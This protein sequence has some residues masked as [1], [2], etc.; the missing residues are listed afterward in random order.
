MPDGGWEPVDP[1]PEGNAPGPDPPGGIATGGR[2]ARSPHRS[3]WLAAAAIAAVVGIVAWTVARDGGGS[4][5][6]SEADPDALSEVRER[7][8]QERTAGETLYESHRDAQRAFARASRRLQVAGSFAYQGT[9]H[10]PGPS[11]ARPAQAPAPDVAV[12]GQV[13]LPLRTH[14]VAVDAQGR[15]AE[16]VTVGPSIWQRS[17]STEDGLA[18]ATYAFAGDVTSWN[19]GVVPVGAGAARL[20]GWLEATVDRRPA[21]RTARS[22][23]EVYAGTLPADR[24]GAVQRGG[25]PVR[26][27]VELTVDRDDVPLRVVIEAFRNE[28]G[29]TSRPVWRLAVDISGLGDPVT[30][31]LPNGELP[32]VTRGPSP[33]DIRVAGIAAPVEL[34]RMPDGWMLAGI[35]LTESTRRGCPVLELRY[36]VIG[37]TDTGFVKLQVMPPGCAALPTTDEALQA[38]DFIGVRSVFPEG[39]GG[40]LSDG[41]T[42][43]QYVSDLPTGD[44]L[45]LLGTLEPYD[46][47]T[48]PTATS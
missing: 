23:L 4:S 33:A 42:M 47:A 35:A 28:H 11:D 22:G 13:L 18:A 14:D 29:A 41:R 25:P 7:T 27:E 48:R 37:F 3:R 10:A 8:D 36:T 2:L 39:K 5:G 24:L 17:A 32:G 16:T 6:S 12:D 46:P 45:G 40:L 26:G 20:P 34:G 43:I 19:G 30:I 9:V 21:E 31:D 44:V 1:W 15:A 38:G